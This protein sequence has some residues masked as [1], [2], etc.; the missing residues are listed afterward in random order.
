[1][2][3][4]TNSNL[5]VSQKRPINRIIYHFVAF[6][7]LLLFVG[8]NI[9]FFLFICFVNEIAKRGNLDFLNKIFLYPAMVMVLIYVWIIVAT[10]T[11]GEM[12]WWP[13]RDRLSRLVPPL[14]KNA[15]ITKCRWT[16]I[17]LSILSA[18]T[19]DPLVFQRQLKDLRLFGPS[20]FYAGVVLL[21][22]FSMI[23][24]FL[25]HGILNPL[26]EID[27]VEVVIIDVVALSVIAPLS[28]LMVLSNF[29][30]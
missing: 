11:L 7:Q 21:L 16:L 14:I 12:R 20:Y 25:F 24:P 10:G 1:M 19:S 29:I 30:E 28:I 22:G 18:L 27:L 26:E 15:T 2:G 3:G 8:W 23:V 4:S 5:K 6:G 13:S 17:V 9:W